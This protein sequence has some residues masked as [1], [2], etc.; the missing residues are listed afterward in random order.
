MF[1]AYLILSSKHIQRHTTHH[2][3][4][5]SLR[6]VP[7][8]AT[9]KPLNP[10]TILW[11]GTRSSQYLDGSRSR[12]RRYYSTVATTYR[13]SRISKRPLRSTRTYQPSTNWT[14]SGPLKH[15]PAIP[16]IFDTSI[17]QL[18][19][20][21]FWRGYD[22][23]V[24]EQLLPCQRGLWALVDDVPVAQCSRRSPSVEEGH[25]KEVPSSP[26]MF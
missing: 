24:Q 7:S 22:H 16:S 1:K 5:L 17:Q 13:S 21:T 12:R 25:D 14:I 19:D 10:Q 3:N 11:N 9:G 8:N 18:L 26:L 4:V 20:D 15:Q 23:G 6:N 2:P